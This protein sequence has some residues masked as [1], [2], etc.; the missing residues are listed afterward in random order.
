MFDVCCAETETFAVV[1][2]FSYFTGT[3]KVSEIF[4]QYCHTNFYY[5]LIFQNF[6]SY[7]SIRL[8]L[9]T[10]DCSAETDCCY[11]FVIC[12]F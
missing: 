11:S 5:V 12:L 2:E 6:W 9:I 10:T 3:C 1:S 4:T 7:I 8:E